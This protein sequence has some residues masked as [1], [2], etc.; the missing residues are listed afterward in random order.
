MTDDLD[1]SL[2]AALDGL[3]TPP[4][5]G[6]PH[7]VTRDQS[8]RSARNKAKKVLERLINYAT[9]P[10]YGGVPVFVSIGG[11]DGEEL[12]YLM[13]RSKATH[14]VLLEYDDTNIKLARQRSDDLKQ[15]YGKQIDII[16]GD[17]LARTRSAVARAAENV[18]DPTAQYIAV[19]CHAILHELY[20]RGTQEFDERSFFNDIFS[21]R[22]LF[23]WFTYREP[24]EPEDWPEDVVLESARVS[25]EMLYEL[26]STIVDYHPS[27]FGNLK[28]SLARFAGG[29]RGHSSLIMETIVKLIYHDDPPGSLYWEMQERS[30]SINHTA[31]IQKL[32]DAI[33]VQA[34]AS[35]HADAVPYSEATNSFIDK[36]NQYRL[37]VRG[38]TATGSRLLPKAMS[39]TRVVAW[40]QG[41][42]TPSTLVSPSIPA[43][44][45]ALNHRI[46]AARQNPSLYEYLYATYPDHVLHYS[47]RRF[48]VAV[49]RAPPAQEDDVDSILGPLAKFAGQSIDPEF[50]RDGQEY[51]NY[52]QDTGS[53]LW[54]GT[55]YRMTELAITPKLKIDSALGTYFDT[56]KS[57]DI[58]N[59]EISKALGD[60]IIAPNGHGAFG[61][62]LK[63]RRMIHDRGDAFGSELGRSVAISFSTVIVFPDRGKVKVLASARSARVATHK[64]S[65]HVVP[66][67]MFSPE[68]R[69]FE[70]EYSVR[71]NFYREYLEELYGM[72]ELS[73]M[74]NQIG[75]D[76]FYND[77]H[78]QYLRELERDGK[79]HLL[80]SGV[81]T[82]LLTMRPEI[83]T[84][85]LIEDPEWIGRVRSGGCFKRYDLKHMELNWEFAG[86]SAEI[87]GVT[88]AGIIEL[89]ETLDIPEV[90]L[91]A[92]RW[93]EVGIGS[94]VL[95]LEVARRRLRIARA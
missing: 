83:C 68:L 25:G 34:I 5:Q 41:D 8:R 47:G 78:L 64:H 32:Q 55:T 16:Q 72:S 26:A 39:Q 49:F 59:F 14:G 95:G 60:R 80:L 70:D 52:L 30:T 63:L 46:A 82:S 6:G 73:R 88:G 18:T 21:Q 58:L 43:S 93:V 13:E 2:Q 85:L 15:Q 79:A 27:H 71:H 92:T 33:D 81:S 17:A 89:T 53:E 9:N 86:T 45:E 77:P 1:A 54:N 44:A 40:R 65:L 20:D 24:G 74:S 76:F 36:C 87:E 42:D 23:T 12:L 38:F 91:D 11:G 10:F 4:T 51:M 84:V 56:V 90:L 22:R 3:R 50:D 19:T 48:P 31:L 66:S 37:V 67:A 69:L 61:S 75:H 35:N 57:C 28:P 29:I 94:L 7:F 62:E